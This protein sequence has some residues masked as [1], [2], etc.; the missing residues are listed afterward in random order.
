MAGRAQPEND[1]LPN[2]RATAQCAPASVALAGLKSQYGE[3][4]FWI[5]ND[6][7]GGSMMLTRAPDGKSWTLLAIGLDDSGSAKACMVAAGVGTPTGEPM[8]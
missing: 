7:D 6:G 4:P 8:Q 2:S 3:V 1:V 5:G